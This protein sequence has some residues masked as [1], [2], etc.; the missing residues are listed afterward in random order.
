MLKKKKK[1]NKKKEDKQVEP[2]I[3]SKKASA[4]PGG[5]KTDAPSAKKSPKCPLMA[6]QFVDPLAAL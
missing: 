2:P 3:S 1:K 4:S 5:Q 6:N